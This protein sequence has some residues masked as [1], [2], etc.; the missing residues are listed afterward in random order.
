MWVEKIHN[1]EEASSNEVD[2]FESFVKHKLWV[3]TSLKVVSEADCL[4]LE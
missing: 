4:V 3:L 2:L 1:D